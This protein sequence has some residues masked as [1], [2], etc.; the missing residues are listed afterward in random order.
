MGGF[1]NFKGQAI[2][3]VFY[4]KFQSYLLYVFLE[5]E[6]LWLLSSFQIGYLIPK[7]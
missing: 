3:L 6:G 5:E 4:I 7:C 2:P 1:S